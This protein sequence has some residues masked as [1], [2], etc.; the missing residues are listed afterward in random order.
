MQGSQET[1][2]LGPRAHDKYVAFLDVFSVIHPRI[3]VGAIRTFLY[4]AQHEGKTQREIADAIGTTQ[5]SVS[6][7]L[8]LLSDYTSRPMRLLEVRTSPVDRRR[9]EYAL[10]RKGRAAVLQLGAAWGSRYEG[11]C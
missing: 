2:L 5:A 3:E 9:K 10:T 11:G 6:R 1:K 7:N 4:V 8:A